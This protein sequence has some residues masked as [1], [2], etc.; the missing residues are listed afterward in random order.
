LK[1]NYEPSN[2]LKFQN[3][4]WRDCYFKIDFCLLK[5]GHRHLESRNWEKKMVH[6]S[7]EK[8]M[9]EIKEKSGVVLSDLCEKEMRKNKKIKKERSDHFTVFLMIW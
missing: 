8:K 6:E 3:F 5:Q 1:D 4:G 9:G 7:W 2:L